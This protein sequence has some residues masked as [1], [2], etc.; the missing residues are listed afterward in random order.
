MF[1]ALPEDSEPLCRSETEQWRERKKSFTIHTPLALQM[2]FSNK[3]K[4][5]QEGQKE[6]E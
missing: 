6:E 4:G 2:E 5:Q 3:F 1:Q